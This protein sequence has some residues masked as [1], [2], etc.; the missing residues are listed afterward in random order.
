M[1]GIT[2]FKKLASDEQHNLILALLP[3]LKPFAARMDRNLEGLSYSVGLAS[4]QLDLRDTWEKVELDVVVL[5]VVVVVVVVNTL[6]KVEREE[7]E[8]ELEAA[9][10]S[11]STLKLPVDP[12]HPQGMMMLITMIMMIVRR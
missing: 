3:L 2:D 11:G 5:V 7:L 10:Y 9:R 12:S 1:I 4:K 8:G 6:D